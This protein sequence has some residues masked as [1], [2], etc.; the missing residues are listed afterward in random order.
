MPDVVKA[1]FGVLGITAGIGSGSCYFGIVSGSSV[2]PGSGAAHEVT[3]AD[4][5]SAAA[6]TERVKPVSCNL[7]ALVLGRT[8]LEHYARVSHRKTDKMPRDDSSRYPCPESHSPV[9]PTLF[10][11][12]QTDEHF[13]KSLARS[14]GE[15]R[16]PAG[17]A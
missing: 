4:R 5:K 8:L 6:D 15:R 7:M 16:G 10:E 3:A 9:M 12:G 13:K 14:G 1:G 11:I 2:P 17:A